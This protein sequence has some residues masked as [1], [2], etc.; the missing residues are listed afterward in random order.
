MARKGVYGPYTLARQQ[1]MVCGPNSVVPLV[2][3]VRAL[4]LREPVLKLLG[5]IVA[6]WG[7]LGFEGSPAEGASIYPSVIMYCPK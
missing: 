3:N 4:G 1:D 5:P 2:L 7:L 6:F